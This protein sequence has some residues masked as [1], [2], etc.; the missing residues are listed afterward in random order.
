M[1]GTNVYVYMNNAGSHTSFAIVLGQGSMPDASNL[2]DADWLL[3][4]MLR[5]AALAGES[6]LTTYFPMTADTSLAGGPDT[7][8]VYALEVVGLRIAYGGSSN[9]LAALTRVGSGVETARIGA[10]VILASP[11]PL[12]VVVGTK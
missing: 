7:E 4:K 6:T 10:P 5:N 1:Q 8:E 11:G 9:K 3:A 2:A 12:W